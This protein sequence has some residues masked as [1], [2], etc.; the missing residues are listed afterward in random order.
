MKARRQMKILE[1][2]AAKSIS[3]QEELAEELRR[4]GFDVTQATLSRDIKELRLVKI[5][6]GVESYRYAQPPEQDSGDWT[7]RLRRV[8]R[9][10][11]VGINDSE[12][13][14]LIRTVTG[15]AH[16]VA[17]ALDHTDWPEVIGTVAGDDTIL[18]IVKPK[19]AV[20]QVLERFHALMS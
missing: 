10:M 6:V 1:I 18:V 11:V 15:H 4:S 5:P 12:N 16:A 2:I 20:V 7:E 3:T 9:D 13:L 19:E 8:F 17:A 14:I